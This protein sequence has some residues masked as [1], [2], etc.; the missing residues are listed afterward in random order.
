MRSN[1]NPT[2]PWTFA[3]S[4]EQWAC[5]SLSIFFM[6]QIGFC[7]PAWLP[8]LPALACSNWQDTSEPGHQSWVGLGY[9]EITQTLAVMVWC[10]P[11]LFYALV[12]LTYQQMPREVFLSKPD[13]RDVYC[14]FTIEW[15][16]HVTSRLEVVWCLNYF[17]FERDSNRK[18]PYSCFSIQAKRLSQ[19]TN[20]L[21]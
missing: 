9:L 15:V 3:W 8:T 10:C 19:K 7:L 11:S 16:D 18:L 5:G 1:P 6:S 20:D 13:K 4:L 17:C 12:I 14:C 2:F 21:S